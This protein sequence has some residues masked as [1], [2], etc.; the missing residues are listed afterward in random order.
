MRRGPPLSRALLLLLLHSA[1]VLGLHAN[2]LLP[3]RSPLRAVQ[4][5]LS[6]PAAPTAEQAAV[7]ASMDEAA[8]AL[9]DSADAAKPTRGADGRLAP[10]LTL[11]GDTLETTH[12]MVGLTAASTL[13]ALGVV[14]RAFLLSPLPLAPLC[15]VAM[16][17]L[18]GELF[19]GTFHWATDNYAASRRPSSALRA[20]AFQGTTSRRDHLPSESVQ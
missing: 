18:A 13:L 16:G 19:S 20:P 2:A 6:P 8:I 10:V 12:L 1:G 15:A 5:Q 9:D 14:V 3:S 4:M 17:G 11:P 7:V